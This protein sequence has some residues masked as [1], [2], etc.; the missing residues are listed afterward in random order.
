VQEGMLALAGL[1][2]LLAVRG[3]CRQVEAH[4]RRLE[5]D[6]VELGGASAVREAGHEASDE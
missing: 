3:P 5:Q 4:I 6:E 2:M 1:V